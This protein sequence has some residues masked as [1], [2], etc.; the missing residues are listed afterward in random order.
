MASPGSSVRYAGLAAVAAPVLAA[1]VIRWAVGSQ[2]LEVAAASSIQMEAPPSV[3]M[4]TPPLT[5]QQ[6]AAKK[7]ALQAL[8]Q[9]FG[10]SPM[11]QPTVIPVV[12][13]Q[14]PDVELV[15]K[16]VAQQAALP[17]FDVTSIL[18]STRHQLATINGK[19]YRIGDEIVPGWRLESIDAVRSVVM[20]APEIGSSIEAA[21]R[22]TGR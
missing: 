11:N 18:V 15:P 5:E 16:P 12:I 9:S 19:L 14:T 20:I 13:E 7:F 3:T 8:E 2:P 17:T 4:S 10:S 6:Q 1:M 21:V 22:R